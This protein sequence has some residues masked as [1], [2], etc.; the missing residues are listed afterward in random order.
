MALKLAQAA[1]LAVMGVGSSSVP[2]AAQAPAT[3]TTAGSTVPHQSGTVKSVEVQSF[4]LTTAAG[5]EV[6]VTVP[7]G[8]AVL[9][10][11]PGSHDL[12]SAQ[13]GTVADIAAG[14]RAIVN[15]SNGD[16]GAAMQATR[17]IVMKSGAI[18]AS[19]ASE[20]A[21]WAKG[22][23]GIVRSVDPATGVMVLS[24]GLR[25][26]TVSTSAATTVQR[27]AGGSVRFEDAVVSS[28]GAIHPGDQVRVRGT[29][30]AN[31]VSGANEVSGANGESIA[32][33]AIVAGS[34]SNF[35]GVLIAVD[36][37]TG[38]VTLKDLA[39]KKTVSVAV[40]AA[41]NV[42]RL[43][44]GAAQAMASREAGAGAEVGAGTGAGGST[45]AGSSAP[46]AGG[47]QNRAGGAGS[48]SAGRPG[49]GGMGGDLSRMVN[50]LPP[51]TLANLKPG[52]AVMIVASN[53][54]GSGQPTAIT[55]LAGVE[56]IL[57]AHPTGGTTLSP[58]NLGGSEGVA[59]PGG[60]PR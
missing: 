9:L 45:P 21:A 20:Q 27:Y 37:A 11:Q 48:G 42:R 58:W 17:V 23:G 41:S 36:A 47:G 24:S 10:V 12:K 15:G 57:A 32:A 59:E 39:S 30:G 35:S 22:L 43:P 40:T 19:R 44:A 6:T 49:G 52:D 18:A 5:Q 2:L 3:P 8:T 54:E 33:D 28:L 1:L 4:V 34:F 29:R 55:L 7:G 14:D 38:T 53:G 16:A 50:R 51:E 46:G 13:A 25:T 60:E 56:Q 31:G 26:V